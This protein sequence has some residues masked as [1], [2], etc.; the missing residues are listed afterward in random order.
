[1]GRVQIVEIPHEKRKPV[2]VRTDP[3]LNRRMAV[4]LTEW[5]AMT[6]EHPPV[7]MAAGC[8]SS[9]HQ[10]CILVTFRPRTDK[11]TVLAFT[12]EECAEVLDFFGEILV[13]KP[14]P[15][16]QEMSLFTDMLLLIKQVSD[17]AIKATANAFPV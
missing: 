4:L 12:A 14:P 7:E 5:M 8:R 9:D 15:T 16:E 13:T 10:P 1:M 17:D 11:E 2:E 6:N 3:N